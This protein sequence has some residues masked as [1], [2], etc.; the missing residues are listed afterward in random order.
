MAGWINVFPET[1]CWC[2]DADDGDDAD[3]DD[4]DAVDVDAFDDECG[5]ADDDDDVDERTSCLH[6]IPWRSHRSRMSRS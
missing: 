5:D 4:D 2:V 3:D 6:I 1:G